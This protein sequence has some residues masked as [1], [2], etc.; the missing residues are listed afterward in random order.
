MLDVDES[1]T[2]SRDVGSRP[3]TFC[4]I[5]QMYAAQEPH[6]QAFVF[7]DADGG[8][9]DET[10]YS[11]LDRRARAIANEL[12]V[13]GLGGF[14]LFFRRVWTLSQLCSGAFMPEQWLCRFHFCP[15]NTLSNGCPQSFA[16]PTRP[17]SSRWRD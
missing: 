14:C 8:V 17:A 2:T 13:N 10:N 6:R 15:A 5:L 16:M 1:A 9:A 11:G 4:D 3:A 12:I 7:L